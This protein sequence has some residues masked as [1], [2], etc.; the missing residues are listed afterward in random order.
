[1]E[2][3]LSATA[4][5]LIHIICKGKRTN[6]TVFCEIERYNDILTPHESRYVRN[7]LMLYRP[8]VSRRAFPGDLT[9]P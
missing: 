2:A 8:R 3:Q 6:G 7:A 9:R 1:M 4:K 5:Y